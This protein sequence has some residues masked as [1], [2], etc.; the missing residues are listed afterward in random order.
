MPYL[1]LGSCCP[2]VLL[3]PAL[4]QLKPC[5]DPERIAAFCREPFKGLCSSSPSQSR[6]LSPVGNRQSFTVLLSLVLLTSQRSR[7]SHQFDHQIKSKMPAESMEMP[8]TNNMVAQPQSEQPVRITHPSR[9]PS[10]VR[11]LALGHPPALAIS[12]DSSWRSANA[13]ISHHHS[14]TCSLA[15]WHTINQIAD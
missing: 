15:S 2:A 7:P 14:I 1:S 12:P 4:A 11:P 13:L 6:R 3:T 10:F 8:Q 9:G 5:M